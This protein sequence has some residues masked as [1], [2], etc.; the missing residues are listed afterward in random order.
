MEEKQ[1]TSEVGLLFGEWL[2]NNGYLTH[3]RLCE[4]LS[5]QHENGGRL[6]EVLLRLK[7]LDDDMITYA[8]AEYLGLEYVQLDAFAD[9]DLNVAKVIPEKIAKRFCLVA[10]SE[11][12]DGQVVVA[13][14]DPLNI[15][16]I[17]TVTLKIKCKIKVVVSSV[18]GIRSAI[19]S[20]Y[21]GSHVAEQRLRELVELELDTEEETSYENA[22]LETDI[23][24]DEEAAIQAPVIRFVNLLLSQAV[25]K[26]A[27]DVHI[28][29][30]EKSLSVRM[31]V[32]GILR[33]TVA[34]PHKLHSAVITRIKILSGMN[35]AERR[36]PQ[37]GRLK[38]KA[39]GR[40]ID[41]RVSSLP[42]IYGEKMVMRILD[43]RAI[44]H[45]LDNLGFEAEFLSEFKRV[46][47]QP[48]GIIVVTGPTGSGKTTTL[49]SALNYLKDESK[50]ITTVENPV[51]YRLKGINQVQ[52]K[53]SIGLDFAS[54]LRTILRQDPDIIMIGEI[55][56]KETVEIAIQASLTGHLVLSTFHTNDAAGA[57]SRLVYMGIEPYLLVSSLNLVVA[58]R[59]VRRLCNNCKEVTM[60]DEQLLM[61]LKID[62]HQAE[63]ATFY[64]ARGCKVCDNT[65]YLGRLPIFELLS[66][67][68]T[69]RE[70]ITSGVSEIRLR[71]MSRESG[72]GSL[73]DSGAQR[74]ME[75]ITA[76]DEVLK[77]T[78]SGV[79]EL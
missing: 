59:L 30:Q 32:D 33:E 7:M 15:I 41:V 64:K 58:Q 20:V 4:A 49:Y 75:G 48:Y 62:P 3:R 47:S 43:K 25:R 17:D 54:S 46:L 6:G 34:P 12:D 31:R 26:K 63:R 45:E 39:P 76:A 11:A 28:E 42:T 14:A 60:L 8:L 61:Q 16:A 52:I 40:D 72:G 77:A 21:H 1:H 74:I 13:M 44:S 24:T 73:L 10:L 2:V 35:I 66:L 53:P 67:D 56:D 57:I 37:D 27:S 19:E 36:L 70:A 22:A 29:P 5:D 68:D 18:R 79:N 71:A 51:E 50:N 69:I 9:I 38:I 65:G 23:S 78:Y 55:R